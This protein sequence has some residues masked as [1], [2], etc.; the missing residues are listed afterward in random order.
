MALLGKGGMGEVHRARDINLGREVA[1]KVI[2][3]A[4][5]SDPD[6]LARFEREARTLAALNHPNIAAVYGLETIGDGRALVMELVEGADLSDRI[7]GGSLPADEALHIATQIADALEAAHD[8][9]VI[10]RDL[11]PANVKVRADGTIKVLDFG[12]AKALESAEASGGLSV[13]PTITTPAMTRA[14]IILGTAAYMSPEQARGKPLDRRADIWAF[15]C[16]LFEML[17]G[18]RPFAD[19]ETVSDTL[20]GILKGEPAWDALP[21]GTSPRLRTLIERC[22]R[23][24]PRR[25]LSHIAEARIAIEEGQGDVSAIAPSRPPVGRGWKLVWPAVAVIAG[26]TSMALAA[27]I[28]FTPEVDRVQARFEI[29]APPGAIPMIGT[30]TSA[31]LVDVGE[32]ISPD[33]RMIAFVADYG[34]RP[35]IWIRPLD[36]PA[37]RPLS[38][39]EDAERPVWSPDSRWLAF[40]SQGR[41]RRVGIAGEPAMN[42]LS[43]GARDLSWGN[44]N[45]ILLGG[46]QGKPL[47]RVPA[48]GGSA[49]PVTTLM[50][51]ETS[52]D[53][54]HFLPDGRTFLFM[55]RHGS[56]AADWDVYAA[57]LDSGERHLLRG[58][59]AGARYAPT[60]HLLFV[61]SGPL[62]LMAVPFSLSR[63]DITGDPFRLNDGI[64]DGP[65]TAF[66]LS[67]NGTFAYLTAPPELESQLTWFDRSGSQVGTLG[68]PGRYE[69]VRLS[70]DARM[71]AFDDGAD[72]LTRE[73]ERGLTSK[74]ISTGGADFAPVFSPD[75][76]A[77]AFASSRVPATNAGANNIIAG[78]LYTKTLGAAGDGEMLFQS[79]GGKRT[80]DWSRDGR[81]VAYTLDNDVWALP[82]PPSPDA[83]PVQVTK[84]PFAESAAVFSPDGQWIA[85]QA[86]DSLTGQDVYVQ[87]FPAGTRRQVSVRGG[88]TPRWKHD[89]SELFYVS[90][91][92]QLM[93]VSITR[94]ASG[95][96]ISKPVQL[97]QLSALQRNA[98]YD[99]TADD[100]FLVAVPLSAPRD[101]A[102]EVVVNWAATLRP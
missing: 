92:S 94:N 26:A 84:T 54:P 98:D 51:G 36:S 45:V 46:D 81:Y 68:P 97:F 19:E 47:L 61:Q 22:L 14:G 5:A 12:L 83:K 35:S 95:L 90:R 69:R 66:S 53:Y 58:I 30:K 60:G 29:P 82:M 48:D 21:S 59:H 39:T 23:K 75:G 77:I 16:V 93:S 18:R 34:G 49:V 44:Q 42:I 72:I 52:H 71:V 27:R 63:L 67:R 99:V 56:T 8:H 74:V 4:F 9:G 32:P 37:A 7:A 64:T 62:Q 79:N 43:T 50:E 85:Y 33:G 91:D 31:R 65:R 13:S 70:R 55:V 2:P 38:G 3:D 11:K 78:H 88:S 96:A 100:R 10:H 28:V 25:R 20:A 101:D 89:G 80:T 40:L 86:N 76:N 41:L 24:D 87:S 102:I 15:G 57:R 73:I 17:A 6:R 1:I